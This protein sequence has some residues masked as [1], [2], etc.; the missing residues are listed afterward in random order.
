MFLVLLVSCA[1][2]SADH[3][4]ATA[5]PVPNPSREAYQAERA[6]AGKSA[7]AQV[8]LALW[9]EAQGLSAERIKHLALA[10]LYDPS[11]ALA[12]GLMGLVAHQGKWERPE[13]ISQTVQNDPQ[14]RTRIQEYLERRAK[15]PDR[16]EDQ[17]KLALW[18]EQHDL[19]P[20]ATAHLFRVLQLDPARDAAWKHLGYKRIGGRWDKPDRVAAAKAEAQQ[21]HQANNH[22]KPVLEKL[23]SGLA[24]KDKA[25]Q[26]QTEKGLG[27]VSDPRAVP[28]IWVMFA[29]GGPERQKVA[30]RLLG[31]IDSPGSSRAL[32]L[33]A[34]MG[35][36]A[37]LKSAA[38]Q[39]LK[40]RDP[41]D[42]AGILIAFLRDPVKFE[43]RAVDGPG[44]QGQLVVKQKDANVKRLYST[45]SAPN[46]ALLPGD[47]VSLDDNGLP[48]VIRE[49]GMYEGR[50]ARI[51][52]ASYA[53]AVAAF[54]LA[55][56]QV[57]A[58][59][60]AGLLTQGGMPAAASQRLGAKVAQ[61][62]API[63]IDQNAGMPGSRLASQVFNRELEI[64]VGQMMMDAQRS[65]QSAQAQLAADVQAIENY[66]AG[67]SETNQ[68][69]RQLLSDSV[70]VDVGPEKESWDKW[71]TDLA[72]YAF[73]AS[74]SYEPPTIVEE[75]PIAYQ[76]GATPFFIDRP[77]NLVTMRHSCFG[78]GTPVRTLTGSA[79]IEKLRAGDLVLVQDAATGELK[80]EPIV[81]VFHNPPN[82]TLRIDMGTET[83][84]ATG[85]HRFW[86]AGRGWVMA[87]DL[88]AGDTLR[89]L[90]GLAAVR[91]VAPDRVQPVFNLRI[92]EGES[93]FVGRAGILAHDNSLIR[94]TPDPFD[95]VAKPKS[96]ATP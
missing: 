53:S 31:Q 33:L 85:I 86:M 39:V 26:A 70:G 77:T 3:P 91:S 89:T 64:P 44:S 2:L 51:G 15:A 21:Q 13:Q 45:P 83:I 55:T 18:C 47:Q 92:A 8:R 62:L 19:K 65:A 57:T 27:E 30:V 5:D 52:D 58:A 28:M 82:G 22:W 1:F 56:P 48:V 40:R 81:T 46:V 72:G 35:R 79:A 32:A 61:N 66:N 17:W 73:A 43:V 20:Q 37:Q 4:P 6:K 36:S 25:R 63:V 69:V 94:P 60:L 87:R 24:S 74:S 50:S 29:H 9:C 96:S 76:Q 42:F 14:L 16:A 67:I 88:K 71:L 93:F 10:V 11:N 7:D 75:V 78:V 12:R 80:Y 34:L 90:G 68:S 38:S 95:A 54:G 59:E 84:V 41:R 49:L 23:Q